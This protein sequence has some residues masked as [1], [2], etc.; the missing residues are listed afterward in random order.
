[1]STLNVFFSFIL[2]NG[3]LELTWY[4]CKVGESGVHGGV[5]QPHIHAEQSKIPAELQLH[6]TT[7]LVF[8]LTAQY[9]GKKKLL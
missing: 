2:I 1:M 8:P 9:G 5:K 6:F 3:G 4:V 7:P